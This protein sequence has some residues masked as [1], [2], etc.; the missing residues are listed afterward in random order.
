MRLPLLVS[1]LA[2]LAP[3]AKADEVWTTRDGDIVYETEIDGAA[4][5]SFTTEDGA[6]ATLVFPNLAGNYDNRGTHHGFWLGPDDGLCDMTM[7]FA[8]FSSRTWG[9]AIVAF[10]EPGFPSSLT[11]LTGNC[12]GPLWRS[13]RGETT[14]G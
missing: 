5:W 10:D 13:L 4:I 8:E 9:Q 2:M 12:I 3:N 11:L 1:I 7:S 6:R 14:A